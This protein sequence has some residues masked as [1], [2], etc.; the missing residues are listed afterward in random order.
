MA[1]IKSSNAIEQR[2]TTHLLGSS[3]SGGMIMGVLIGV[4]VGVGLALIVAWYLMKSQPQEKPGV[5]APSAPALMKPLPPKSDKETEEETAVTP[6]QLD[7]NKPL[8][9]KVPGIGGTDP[10]RDPIADIAAGK[11]PEVKP[12]PKAD[13]LFYVQTGVFNQ[14]TDA[15]AQKATLAMQGIQAQL[16]ESAVDGNS[17][18]RVRIGPFGSIEDTTSVRSKLTILGIKPTVIRVNRS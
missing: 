9:T 13:S 8:Q 3:E 12:E 5:R 6:P 7:L 2:S 11:P 1:K 10:T 15:D 4:F 17:V 14:R 16:S 18:W